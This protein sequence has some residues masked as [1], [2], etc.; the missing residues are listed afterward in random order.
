MRSIFGQ[1]VDAKV[2]NGKCHFK[3]LVPLQLGTDTEVWA[4]DDLAEPS[5]LELARLPS[6]DV[7]LQLEQARLRASD[8]WRMPSLDL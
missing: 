1:T 7:A 3:V 6:P 4:L 2:P 5:G 8:S